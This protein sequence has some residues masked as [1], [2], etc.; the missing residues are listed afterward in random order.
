MNQKNWCF[1]DK[2][3]AFF[4]ETG[5]FSSKLVLTGAYFIYIYTVYWVYFVYLYSIIQ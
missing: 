2:T 1:F 3:G 4:W 5:A